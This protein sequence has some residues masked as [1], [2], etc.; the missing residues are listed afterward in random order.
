MLSDQLERIAAETGS[1]NGR[2]LA[3]FLVHRYAWRLAGPLAAVQLET[4]TLPDLGPGAVWIKP[5]GDPIGVAFVGDWHA[6]R[7][8]FRA[9]LTAHLEPLIAQLRNR[10]PLGRRALWLIAADAFASAFVAAGELLDVQDEAVERIRGLIL[11]PRDSAF[12]GGTGFFTVTVGG[13]P[14][15][16][17]RRGS[18]CQSFR[19]DGAFCATCPR[20]P[21]VEQR[22]RVAAEL[23]AETV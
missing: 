18:C 16:V 9:D 12:R 2:V 7:T 20:V 1:T 17:V 6:C 4:D 19:V 14:H 15:T 13:R 10:L 22:R 23:G 11:D 8:R 5:D 3:A 21:A